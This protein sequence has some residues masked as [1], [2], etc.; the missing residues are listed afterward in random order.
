[1]NSNAAE[2]FFA[3]IS[4]FPVA[5]LGSQAVLGGSSIGIPEYQRAGRN[6]V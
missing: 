2:W 3:R 6:G 1:M 5:T 4:R